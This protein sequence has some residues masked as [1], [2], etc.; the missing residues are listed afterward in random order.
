M[1]ASSYPVILRVPGTS[2]CAQSWKCLLNKV[3]LFQSPKRNNGKFRDLG[4][5]IF[6][7]KEKKDV[8]LPLL[9]SRLIHSPFLSTSR[10]FLQ[11]SL[12]TSWFLQPHGAYVYLMYFYWLAEQCDE[13]GGE[14]LL[15]LVVPWLSLVPWNCE[16]LPNSFPLIIITIITKASFGVSSLPLWCS[17][18]SPL[19]PSGYF[20]LNEMHWYIFFLAVSFLAGCAF[21]TYKGPAVWSWVPK[22]NP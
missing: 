2:V 9:I 21:R 5:F 4:I 12:T 10:F 16:I 19:F 7:G 1:E 18:F 17:S 14:N 15:L 11:N 6:Y 3:L 22:K 20:L 8:L 13:N